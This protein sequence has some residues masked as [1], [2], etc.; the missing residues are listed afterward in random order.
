MQRHEL[1]LVSLFAG[2]VFVAVAGGYALT[3]TTDLRLHW[4]FAVP[5]LLVLVG[6]VVTTVAV[7]RVVAGREHAEP[8]GDVTDPT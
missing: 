8:I 6:A 4:L 7:R 3:H 1:D 5:A 2:L